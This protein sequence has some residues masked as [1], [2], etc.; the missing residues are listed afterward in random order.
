MFYDN[1]E[2]GTWHN[3]YNDTVTAPYQN[4]TTDNSGGLFPVDLAPVGT[5][6]YVDITFTTVEYD[7][8][9]S[10]DV[11]KKNRYGRYQ[12]NPY[13][14]DSYRSGLSW[15]VCH[16][17]DTI[18]NGAPSSSNNNIVYEYIYEEGKVPDQVVLDANTTYH[19]FVRTSVTGTP[20]HINSYLWF[21]IPSPDVSYRLRDT[22]TVNNEVLFESYSAPY[23]YKNIYVYTYTPKWAGRLYV[24]STSSETT[25][26]FRAYICEGSQS[27]DPSTGIPAT[28]LATSDRSEG[29]LN[30]P[31]SVQTDVVA[32]TTYYVY[33][34]CNE[35]TIYGNTTI[36]NRDIQVRFASSETSSIW[37]VRVSKDGTVGTSNI[38][39]VWFTPT[40]GVARQTG[41][42]STY[43]GVVA[44]EAQCLDGYEFL[45]WYNNSQASTEG[46]NKLLSTSLTYLTNNVS[47][48]VYACYQTANPFA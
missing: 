13:M 27:I 6:S 46:S 33:V 32:N 28:Y 43:K 23:Y 30:P 5:G 39:A 9:Y 14:L 22:V 15:W 4:Y 11:F 2:D 41:N 35:Y 31:Q 10:I 21:K 37:Y 1:I 26:P 45:G 18:V 12:Y 17:T 24:T 47:G 3:A 19:L 40:N 16:N 36:I 7:G 48:T 42:S 29:T 8:G 34:I 38:R 25:H 20:V 44:L